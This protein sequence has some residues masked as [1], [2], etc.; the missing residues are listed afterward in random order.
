ME[1]KEGKWG[2]WSWSLEGDL[3]GVRLVLGKYGVQGGKGNTIRFWTDPWCGNNVL[4]QSFPNL[5]SM[6][7]KGM[8][9][10]RKHGIRILVKEGGT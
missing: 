3:E 8:S 4:S 9:Q 1:D 10:W 7:A 6:V 2:V 5:F